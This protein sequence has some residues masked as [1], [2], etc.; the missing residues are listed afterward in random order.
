MHKILYL[1]A[2]FSLAI[3]HSARAEVTRSDYETVIANLDDDA[4]FDAFASK[5]P[6]TTIE[7]DNIKR[8]F[9]VLEGDQLL[10]KEQVRAQ[11]RFSAFG[12]QPAGKQNSELLVMTFAGVPQYWPKDKRQLS[13]SIRRASFPSEDAYNYVSDRMWRAGED[14]KKKCEECGV[15][16]VHRK[17]FDENPQLTDVLFIVTF[18]PNERN[19]IAAAFFPHEPVYR[20]YLIIAPSFFTTNFDRAGVLRHELGHVLGYRHE[21]IQGVP[22]CHWEDNNWA[23]LTGYDSKSVMHYFCGGAGTRE[24]IISDTDE[25]GHRA[26]Y[27]K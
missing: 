27:G 4:V 8:T 2:L 14:W 5:L 11:I 25:I 6:T 20:R 12:S 23:P 16:F 1:L 24:M 22:G 19:F 21:H 17:E 13:Y 18:A 3:A 7:H 9:L 10:T 26:L 15:S